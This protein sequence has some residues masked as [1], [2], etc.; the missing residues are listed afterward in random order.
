MPFLK[1]QLER[2]GV[3]IKQEDRLC[4]QCGVRLNC[5]LARLLEILSVESGYD[6]L[7]VNECDLFQKKEA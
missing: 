2:F 7:A 4:L 3:G 1:I 5:R 6:R